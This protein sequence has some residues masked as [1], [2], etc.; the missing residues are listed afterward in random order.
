MD[1]K[2]KAENIKSTGS[3]WDCKVI[4]GNVPIISGEEENL[5]CAILAGFIQKSTIPQLPDVGVPW[6]DFLTKKITFGELDY[7]IRDNLLKVGREDYTPQYEIDGNN[8]TM[9]MGKI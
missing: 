4:N 7:Y 1:L 6:T 8:L 2:M 3:T 9:T 5:Q